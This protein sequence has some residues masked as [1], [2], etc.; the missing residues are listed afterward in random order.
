MDLK[1]PSQDPKSK[2]KVIDFKLKTLRRKSTPSP[3]HADLYRLAEGSV[4]GRDKSRRSSSVSDTVVAIDIQP[5]D[6]ARPPS[7]SALVSIMQP[8]MIFKTTRN[9]TAWPL[10]EAILNV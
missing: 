10:L 6:P 4:A 2:H 8:R 7:Q 9:L 5:A 1:R 3:R